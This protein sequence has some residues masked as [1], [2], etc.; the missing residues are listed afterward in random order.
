MESSPA[1]LRGFHQRYDGNILAEFEKFILERSLFPLPEVDDNS[2]LNEE[3]SRREYWQLDRRMII[4]REWQRQNDFRT[5]IKTF[6]EKEDARI[7]N[8]IG[9]LLLSDYKE[10]IK[11]KCFTE[12]LEG[13]HQAKGDQQKGGGEKHCSHVA[14]PSQ[15][16]HNDQKPTPM[17]RPNKINKVQP[18]K[19]RRVINGYDI[20]RMP[21]RSIASDISSVLPISVH[22]LQDN[23]GEVVTVPCLVCEETF[24]NGRELRKHLKVIHNEEY[25]QLPKC[26]ECGITFRRK[27]SAI[28]HHL[29][30]HRGKWRPPTPFHSV[31]TTMSD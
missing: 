26:L 17:L 31:G 29:R 1:Y 23:T 30:L 18:D 9:N 16:L 6:L 7:N 12:T 25:R 27:D 14:S 13:H 2:V 4:D 11:R 22:S 10:Y 24:Q 8:F 28:N 20:P 15:H 21:P 3:R 5:E 19:P